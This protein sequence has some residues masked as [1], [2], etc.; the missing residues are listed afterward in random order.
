MKIRIL[1]VKRFFDG[2]RFVE[3]LHTIEIAAEVIRAIRPGAVG[4]PDEPYDFLM[5]ALT[6]SH[7]HLFLDGDEHANAVRKAHLS[8]TPE[9]LVKTG[10][11]NL[12]RYREAGIRTVRDAGDVYGVNHRLRDA[13]GELGM[14][15]VSAGKAVRKTGRYG[16]FMAREL[17][18]PEDIPAAVAEIARDADALKIVLSGIIDFAHGQ[19]KGEPQFSSGEL[20]LLVQCAH[21]HEIGRASCRE[22]V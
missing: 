19:V 14:R 20:E 5:P 3:G 17:A 4:A 10:L 12:A 1:Q 6:E 13:A 16:S 18:G 7:C 8:K 11:D 9:Q 21:E 22:R 15:V 2:F